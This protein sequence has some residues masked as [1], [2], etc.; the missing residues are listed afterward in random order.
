MSRG[1]VREC[2]QEELP[3]VPPRADLPSDLVNYVTD[4]GYEELLLERENMIY[5]RDNLFIPDENEK[6][7][8]INLINAKLNLL[9][10]RIT[11]A[12]IIITSKQPK[13]KVCFGAEVFF[14]VDSDPQINNYKIVGV[15]E[16]N[17]AKGKIAFNSPVAKIMIDKKVG[18]IAILKLENTEKTFKIISIRY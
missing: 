10:N 14:C 15:D 17:I 8:T 18:D 11:T 6:R 2:D 12:K 16:A 4:T 13:S 3:I 9:S 7:I 1:F 5:E